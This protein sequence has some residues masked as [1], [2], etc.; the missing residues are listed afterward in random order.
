MSGRGGRPVGFELVEQAGGLSWTD[1]G[2]DATG[3]E[4]AEHRVQ[5]AGD[6]VVV[7]RQVAVTLRPHLHHRGVILGANLGDRSRTQGGDR[8]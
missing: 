8:H 7:P 2:G 6:P 4:V 5:P 1:L 3:D